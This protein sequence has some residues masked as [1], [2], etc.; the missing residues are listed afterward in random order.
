MSRPRPPPLCLPKYSR[1]GVPC[2]RGL[3]PLG[4]GSL[5]VS[6]EYDILL[7]SVS[8]PESTV[9]TPS[10]D[11]A[12]LALLS[13]T[14][15]SP[16]IPRRRRLRRSKVVK[17]GKT[18]RSSSRKIPHP[19][20]ILYTASSAL[21]STK[22][23]F[24]CQASTVSPTGR[25]PLVIPP[26]NPLRNPKRQN[27]AATLL[28]A[29]SFSS[30][31]LSWLERDRKLVSHVLSKGELPL[32]D[33]GSVRRDLSSRLS[34]LAGAKVRVSMF[35]LPVP[36]GT[37]I[38]KL[39]DLDGLMSTESTSAIVVHGESSVFL[40]TL[41]S[42]L[43]CFLR[44][45]LVASLGFTTDIPPGLGTVVHN[46][47]SKIVNEADKT[48][49]LLN[50]GAT[51]RPQA[52]QKASNNPKTVAIIEAMGCRRGSRFKFPL[53]DSAASVLPPVRK[54][55]EAY[56]ANQLDGLNSVFVDSATSRPR[57]LPAQGA[58]LRH[59]FETHEGWT[60]FG[61]LLS[62][63]PLESSL[64][65]TECARWENSVRSVSEQLLL[66]V[67]APIPYCLSG[68]IC[69]EN[70]QRATTYA[71]SIGK[72]VPF[73]DLA[74]SL[75]KGSV[76]HHHSRF[77]HEDD[78]ASLV[79]SVW[80]SLLGSKDCAL[81]FYSKNVEMRFRTTT[82][83]FCLFHGWIPH[84]SGLIDEVVSRS[85]P[86]VPISRIHHSAYSKPLMEFV[87]LSLFRDEATMKEVVDIL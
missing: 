58:S 74:R 34:D 14:G 21:R 16:A 40:C 10:E 51:I 71:T 42:E 73:K 81:S 39:V 44:S 69:Q 30:L 4:Y 6:A 29:P 60:T 72:R 3:R 70:I 49:S 79:P 46:S 25:E 67:F 32:I 84:S 37:S 47:K 26:V 38:R 23:V 9:I 17:P 5:S 59:N 76:G 18:T 43:C 11:V 62:S 15:V 66:D 75:P 87:G 53:S 45:R 7:P 27:H 68:T 55:Y 31:G 20:T 33:W 13:L 54:V 77:A 19:K 82:S 80:T 36:D 57:H 85:I 8:V 48:F 41:S 24:P 61:P 63:L 52:R 56:F 22:S 12:A 65:D 50:Y 28:P 83:R 1:F 86:A 2:D 35:M 64:E 78:N